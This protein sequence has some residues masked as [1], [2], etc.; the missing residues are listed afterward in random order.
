M[1]S[2]PVVIPMSQGARPVVSADL[3]PT[4]LPDAFLDSEEVKRVRDFQLPR[5]Q[6][7]PGLALYRDQVL[8][9]V[10]QVLEPLA[11][12]VDTPVLTGAMIN[13]YVKAGIIPAPEKKHYGR[14][15]IARLLILCLFKQ[16]LS[17]D[18][19]KR[20]FQI[21]RLSYPTE[22]AFDYVA[23]ELEHALQATFA[24]EGTPAD[25]A[26][27]VTRETLMVRAAVSAFAAKAYLMSY[28]RYTGIDRG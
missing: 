21:Q 10:E 7:L 11:A 13:N 18:A 22:T 2:H 17:I 27:Q 8:S 3:S 1:P 9:Y 20:L 24:G 26:T 28:L 5:Y 25:T 19:I 23:V 16:F 14:A 15:H 4:A 12:F 6:N